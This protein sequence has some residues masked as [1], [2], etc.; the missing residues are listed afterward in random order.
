LTVI[1]RQSQIPHGSTGFGAAET[2]NVSYFERRTFLKR[3][4]TL[5]PLLGALALLVLGEQKVHSQEEAA[6][7]TVQV[8]V[9]ITDKALQAEKEIPPFKRED[10]KV[11]PGKNSLRVRQLI[12]AE[13]TNAALQLMIL[14]DDTLN[15]SVG[16]NFEDLKKFLCAQPPS[17]VIAVGYRSNAGATWFKTLS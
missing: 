15:T 3:C 17:T 1:A 4:A 8:Q 7:R 9:V 2:S 10:V 13:G 12:P 5:L 16:N 11:K 14:I 6:P